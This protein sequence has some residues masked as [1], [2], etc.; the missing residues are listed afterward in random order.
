MN[1]RERAPPAA[2]PKWGTVAAVAATAAASASADVHSPVSGHELRGSARQHPG[3][4][5]VRHSRRGRAACG[6]PQCQSRPSR[7]RVGQW[8]VVVRPLEMG[9][10]CS[11]QA[12]WLR[13][14]SPGCP[15]THG[16]ERG[17]SSSSTPGTQPRW[18]WQQQ[19]QQQQWSGSVQRRRALSC[20]RVWAAATQNAWRSRRPFVRWAQTAGQKQGRERCR[21]RAPGV[22]LR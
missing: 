19:Q 9:V 4:R 20:W 10:R 21:P 6:D 15:W 16:A 2:R 22:R 5:R 8:R 13:R 18:R 1:A 12:T 7:C 3:Q 14:G 17:P 11:R